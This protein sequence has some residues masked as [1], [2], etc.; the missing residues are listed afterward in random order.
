MFSPPEISSEKNKSRKVFPNEDGINNTHSSENIF[1]RIQK[2]F[3]VCVVAAAA[4]VLIIREK[5][6]S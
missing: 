1:H 3:G 2:C 4:S 5:I 6:R